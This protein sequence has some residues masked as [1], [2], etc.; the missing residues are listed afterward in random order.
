MEIVNKID[1]L[2]VTRNGIRSRGGRLGL[3]PTMGAL[4]E[5]HLSLIR[6]AKAKSDVVAASIFVNPTQFGPNEDFS[7]YPRDLEK[8]LALLERDGVDLVFVPSVEEMYPQQSVTWVAVEGLSDR[9]CGKSRPGHFRGV[10]TVVAKLFNIVEPDIAF[11]GQKDAAQ[12]AII[13]RMVRDLNMPVAIEAC[14]IVREPDG[15][16]LSS[17]NA[18]LSPQ[19]RQDALVL[20]RSLLRVRELFADGERNPAILIKAAKNVLSGSSAVR[21]D[22]FEIVDPDELTPLA[23]INQPALVAVAAFVGNTRLIDNIVLEP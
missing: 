8:D 23:L 14:P 21:L 19:Q 12:V 16:A 9:L 15:L 5:G 22:Y 3:V 4:H 18:Y 1:E 20:F 13:R 10:A 11:F 2:F 7:R 17:R 6:A